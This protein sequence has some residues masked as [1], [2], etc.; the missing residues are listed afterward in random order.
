MR[1]CRCLT[2]GVQRGELL[3]DDLP[4]VVVAA[5]GVGLEL[6]AEEVAVGQQAHVR[7]AHQVEDRALLVV[8]RAA[9]RGLM[10]DQPGALEPVPDGGQ[11][12]LALG[13]EQLEQVRLRD[14]D[15]PGDRLGR[16]AR[17]AA[18]RER[19]ERG[20]DDRVAALVGGLAGVVAA[21]FMCV[22]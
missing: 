15:R 10:E 6:D 11:E 12:Q 8:G 4:D 17:V 16:G 19:V 13:P 7:V 2:D 3:A 20:G 9:P 22:T 18:F 14:A 5:G 1:R 21:A